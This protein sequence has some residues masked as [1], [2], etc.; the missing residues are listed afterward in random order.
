MIQGLRIHI[1]RL[2]DAI[3]VR[4]RKLDSIR[5]VSP[6]LTNVSD[7]QNTSYEKT[8][9][10]IVNSN[11]LFG[12]FRRIKSYKFIVETVTYDQGKLYKERIE[13]LASLKVGIIEA[14]KEND[15][16]GS[17]LTFR[18]P[19]FGK[20]SP[21]TLR[22]LSVASEIQELFPHLYQPSIAEIGVGYGGQ[23]S[24]LYDSLAFKKYSMFDLPD[25]LRLSSKFLDKLNKSKNIE[26][27]DLS[28]TRTKKW[29][30]VISNYAFSE[31]PRSLQI[32]YVEKVL[33]VSQCGYLIMNSGRENHSGRNEGK[34]TFEELLKLIPELEILPEI[35]NTGKDNYLIYWKN[36]TQGTPAHKILGSFG[37]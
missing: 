24:I 17:P 19:H 36:R 13:E 26:L 27:D 28:S 20:I 12:K 34:L 21:T 18:Y 16:I 14:A 7:S 8:L 31:L 30:L 23:A 1:S 9:H 35:P 25:A 5:A 29:D 6:K 37:E 11:R 10:A 3:Y 4:K 15:K 2:S 22:Y 33:S 32:T